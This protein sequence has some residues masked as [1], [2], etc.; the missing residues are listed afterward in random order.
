MKKD[1]L[2]QGKLVCVD[3]LMQGNFCMRGCINTR[4][5]WAG[6]KDVLIQGRVRIK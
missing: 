1:A 6:K 3:V 4:K 2:L 5:R